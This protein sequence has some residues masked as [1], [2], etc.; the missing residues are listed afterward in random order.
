MNLQEIF[1]MYR[2]RCSTFGLKQKENR[3]VEFKKTDGGGVSLLKCLILPQKKKLYHQKCI[4]T[5][6]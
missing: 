4:K 6:K 2:Y 5:Y 3:S 1:Y